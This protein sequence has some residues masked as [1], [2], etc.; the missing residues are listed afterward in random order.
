M[1]TLWIICALV[2]ADVEAPSF[3][4]ANDELQAYLVE[5]AE[6]NPGLQARYAQWRAALER[7]PQVRS[8]DDP[9]LSY[10]EFIR[11]DMI[12]RSAMLSQKFPWFGTL[13]DR[14]DRAAMNAAAALRRFDDERNRVFAD[15]K[16]AYFEY[17]FLA[18][19]LRVSEAQIEIL[20]YVEEIVR[21]RYSL[22]V[23]SQDDLLRTQIQLSRVRDRYQQ[24]TQFIDPTVARLNTA[25]GR[26]ATESIPWPQESAAPPAPPELKEIVGRVR[27]T[28]PSLAAF[29]DII[30][31]RRIGIELAKRKAYPDFT[32]GTQIQEFL[33]KGMENS[34]ML[35]LGVNVPIWRK[36]IKAGIA[37]ADNLEKAAVFDQ[38]RTALSLEHA[39]ARGLFDYQDG[40]RRS[41]LYTDDLVPQARQTY[42]SLQSAY[43]SGQQD[44]SFIDLLDSIRTLLDF[45]LEEVRATRD[46]Q[47]AAATLEFLMGGPWETDEP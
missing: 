21:F 47:I 12:G 45:E 5:A 10:A 40:L 3:Y 17:D 44:A 20:E 35:S 6:K 42:E 8:L 1:T 27:M 15:V 7:I 4:A 30:E 2:T 46:M 28:N 43:A 33:P 18:E 14:G 25:I 11:G 16:T 19:S 34:F 9:M 39:A 37:E 41:A 36:R 22:G 31:S 38:K 23:A 24:L 32:L 29:D 13:R 26:T